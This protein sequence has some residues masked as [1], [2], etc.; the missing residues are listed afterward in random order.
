MYHKKR[1]LKSTLLL[2]ILFQ[3]P[4]IAENQ[5]VTY[6]AP[7][8]ALLNNAFNV[9]VRVP[10]EPWRPVPTYLVKVDEVRQAQH[11]TM[12]ASMA[13][14]DMKGRVEVRVTPLGVKLKTVRIRPLSY[15]IQHTRKGGAFTFFLD[16][17]SNLSVEVNA[18]IFHNLHLF[19][20]PIMTE[21]PDQNDSDVVYFGPG[22]HTFPNNA[23]RVPSGKTVYVD[24]GAVLRG[25]LLIEDVRDVRVIGRGQVEHTVKMGIHIARSKNVLVEGLFTTQ[26]ATGGS[27]L[28]TIRNVKSISYY[29]WGDGMNVFA[30]SNVLFDRVFCRN[31]DDC[32]TVY[33]TRKGFSGDAR[34][35]TMQHSTLWA[36]VAHPIFIGLHGDADQPDVIENLTYTDIDILDHKEMQ[37][38]YQGCLTI[39]A[40][41]NN[42]VRNVR[43]ENIRVEDFRQGQLVNLRIFFNKKYCRAPGAVIENVLFKDITYNGSN[44]ALSIIAGYDEQRNVRN[45][46]FENLVI[47]GKVI[48]D[49]MPGKPA[50]FKTSDMAGFFVGEHV[51]NLRFVT[52]EESRFKYVSSLKELAYYADQNDYNITMKP[53]VYAMADFLNADSIANR[54]QRKEYPYLTFRGSHNTFN[55]HGVTF[56]IDTKLRK[57]LKHPIH[58]NELQVFGDSNVFNGLTIVHLGNE[59]SPGGATFCVTGQGNTV[60]DFTLRVK[61]SF[62]YGY[63]DLFG[64]G[65][66]DVIR[67]QKQS[68]FLVEGN[69]TTV[70]N[71]NLYMRSFGH[72]FYLQKGAS[73]VRFENC[74]VEGEVRTTDDVL[75]ETNTPAANVQFRTWTANREGKYIVTPGYMK[76]LCEDGFRTYNVNNNDI[77]FINCTAKNT[78]GGFELRTKGGVRL[79]NCTTIGTERAYWVNDGAVMVNCKGDANYGPLLFL[80]GSNTDVDLW[81]VPTESDRKVHAL[82]TIQG[83]NNKVTLRPYQGKQRQQT[84]PI[85]IGYTHPEHGES[86]SPY[87]EA[88]C[89]NLQ[90]INET[91]MPVVKGKAVGRITDDH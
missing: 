64:K 54:L 13:S 23:Y 10:G 22:I 45:I 8:G 19:A 31:S 29:G 43:F 65:G 66:P 72:G 57:L 2:N 12:N 85:M 81:V 63:G 18:D 11:Q 56:E 84:L 89:T 5:L 30:S 1:Y 75:K 69:H 51:E 37:V 73:H 42:V 4:L 62:P 87:S 24:G 6:E 41:D 50:W 86:M 58:T 53:G 61:G 28:V 9:E 44:A 3:L 60:K 33:A 46:C 15:G 49:A 32:T 27:D 17:P 71:T 35:I 74:Y 82:V 70:L 48:H 21:T 47:N 16:K 76:S 83:H 79:E 34:N 91:I 67:H 90:L 78:R 77:T 14:F 7:E 68:G 20:N 26:C 36:D 55:L 39:N 40:G 38:D 88:P 25:Q 52:S 59:T 80:E